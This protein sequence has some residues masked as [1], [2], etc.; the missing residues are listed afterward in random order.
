MPED[1][2]DF[3]WHWSDSEQGRAVLLH[4]DKLTVTFHPT[5]S[6]GVSAIRGAKQLLPNMEHYFEVEMNGPFY[7]QTRMVGIGTKHAVLQSHQFDYYPLLGRDHSSWGLN[8]N[9]SL[10]HQGNTEQY[11]KLDPEKHEI[12]RIGVHYDAYYGVLSFDVNGR[13]HGVAFGNLVT[14]LDLYPMI[15]ASAANSVVKLTHCHSSVLSLKA[16]CRGVIRMEILDE[17]D[18][19]KL[20]LPAKIKAY[21]TYRSQSKESTV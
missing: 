11:V 1:E 7:G 9:G 18:Y 21:L 3:D 2:E 15:C 13:S 4:Q 12:M 10:H 17:K 8:Y 14:S 5:S 16:L 19:E 20:P 6:M